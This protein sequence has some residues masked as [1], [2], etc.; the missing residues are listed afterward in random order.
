[1]YNDWGKKYI[2]CFARYWQVVLAM[3]NGVVKSNTN[4][5]KKRK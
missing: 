3:G 1:M 4:G 5:D 2:K